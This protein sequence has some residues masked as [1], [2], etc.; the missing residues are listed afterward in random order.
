M[1]N[2]FLHAEPLQLGLLID[3][4]QVHVIVTAEAVI[5]GRE[6]TIGIGWQVDACDRAF[7]RKNGID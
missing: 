3:D 5:G 7:L 2:R 4:Y 6:Q 1:S